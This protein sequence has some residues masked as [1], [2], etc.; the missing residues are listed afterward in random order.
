MR[1]A[2]MIFSSVPYN[3]RCD[4][5][6]PSK[7]YMWRDEWLQDTLLMSFFHQ[8]CVRSTFQGIYYQATWSGSSRHLSTVSTARCSTVLCWSSSLQD[9]ASVSI[10]FFIRSGAPT[11]HDVSKVDMSPIRCGGSHY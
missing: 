1:T 3:S 2:F 5:R 10:P 7:R 9:L 8:I 11:A 6:R 4:H